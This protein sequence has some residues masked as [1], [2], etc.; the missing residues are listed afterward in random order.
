MVNAMPSRCV[1]ENRDL[2]PAA[3][4]GTHRSSKINLVSG[5]AKRAAGGHS[6][7]F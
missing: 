6:R 7:L 5:F 1:N 2:C 3:N 4:S